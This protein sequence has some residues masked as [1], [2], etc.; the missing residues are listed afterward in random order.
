MTDWSIAVLVLRGTPPLTK[1]LIVLSIAPQL[2]CCSIL[3]THAKYVC[4]SDAM[5]M[6][7]IGTVNLV[8][9]IGCP[10]LQLI[11]T[12]RL[13]PFEVSC[14]LGKPHHDCKGCGS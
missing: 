6:V 13:P 11:M 14:V 9:L 7:S 12:L 10:G 3:V 1:R 2:V 8:W 4:D 5:R